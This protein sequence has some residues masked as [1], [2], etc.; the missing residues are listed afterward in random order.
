[1]FEKIKSLY[2]SGR[3]TEVNLDV[4]ITKGWITEEQKNEIMNSENILASE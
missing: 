1:M 2:A 4:A 3:I